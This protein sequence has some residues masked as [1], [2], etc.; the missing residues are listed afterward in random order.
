VVPK[1]L[2]LLLRKQLVKRFRRSNGWAVI[3]VDQIRAANR[4]STYSGFER[5]KSI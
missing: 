1:G 4:P 5:R 3:G 2:Q